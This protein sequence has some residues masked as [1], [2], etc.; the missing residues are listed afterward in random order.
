MNVKFL[1]HI[2]RSEVTGMRRTSDGYLVGRV[3]CARTGIQQYKRSELGLMGDG[4]INVYRP[5]EA[6]FDNA[7]FATFAGKPVTKLHPKVPVTADNWKEL[8]VGTVGTKIIRNGDFVEVDIALMDGDIIDTVEHGL[9]RE[10][11]MGYTTPVSMQDGVAPDGTPYE[12]VQTGPISI[13]HLAIVPKARGGDD[14][15]VPLGDSHWGASPVIQHKDSKTMKTI[16]VDGISI[17]TTDQGVQAIAKLQGQIGALDAK[18]ENLSKTVATKDGELAAKDATIMSKDKEIADAKSAIP[19]GPALDALVA[20]RQSLVDAAKLL[21]PDLKLDGLS[22]AAIK[23]A[24]VRSAMGD[25][26]VDAK[27]TGKPEVYAD[28]FYDASF[29]LVTADAQSTASTAA[30]ISGLKPSFTNDAKKDEEEAY[31]RSVDRFNRKKK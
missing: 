19:T 16:I 30:A 7:S 4:L 31:N 26:A 14:L 18:V 6:V 20:E 22:N 21:A 25:A 29:D 2:E 27:I 11:S 17:E 12:A 1:D 28:A 23:K 10:I 15:K 13:N 5:E 9:M 24:V 3:K 8:A